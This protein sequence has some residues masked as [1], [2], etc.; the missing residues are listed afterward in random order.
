M[1]NGSHREAPARADRLREKYAG[2]G[3]QLQQRFDALG[4]VPGTQPYRESDSEITANTSGLHAK[5]IPREAWRWIGVG[6]ALFITC[7][8]VAVVVALL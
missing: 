5:G 1:G 3:R 4:G 7:L 6:I 8:G 2:R